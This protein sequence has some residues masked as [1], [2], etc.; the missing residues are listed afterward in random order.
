MDTWSVARFFLDLL[1]MHII[2]L[3]LLISVSTVIA[4]QCKILLMCM[5]YGIPLSEMTRGGW[6]ETIETF[7]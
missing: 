4:V 6:L 1:L 2:V 7:Y 3:S 5:E